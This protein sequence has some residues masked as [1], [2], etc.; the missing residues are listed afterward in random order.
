MSLSQDELVAMLRGSASKW[1][2]WRKE[3]Q[4]SPVKLPEADFSDAMLIQ[5]SLQRVDFTESNFE[6]A[7][8][9][10]SDLTGSVF[11]DALLG[12]V[13][14]CEAKLHEVDFSG[15]DLHNASFC[16][17]D[18]EGAVLTNTN[19]AGANFQQ[20]RGTPKAD[21]RTMEYIAA[22]RTAYLLYCAK[23]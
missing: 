18:I 11:K 10:H 13:D 4:F 16:G 5:A 12:S 2:A 22:Q 19:L 6:C 14:F 23:D 21:R 17:A 15:A 20:S 1:N 3:N 9:A 8:L 7:V